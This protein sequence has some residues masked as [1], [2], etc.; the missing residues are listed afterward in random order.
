MAANG[1]VEHRGSYVVLVTLDAGTNDIYAN[2]ESFH[3]YRRDKAKK[4]LITIAVY[5]LLYNSL[6]IAYESI[7]LV[8]EE[9]RSIQSVKKSNINN[10]GTKLDGKDDM[11]KE[12]ELYMVMK[13]YE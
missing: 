6:Q 13:D 12:Y 4:I 1:T 2:D 9:Q 10:I 11:D 7:V 3:G 8:A 5:P